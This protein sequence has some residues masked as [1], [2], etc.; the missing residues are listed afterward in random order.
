MLYYHNNQG[1]KPSSV[2]QCSCIYR[3]DVRSF[4]FKGNFSYVFALTATDLYDIVS[5]IS[6]FASVSAKYPPMMETTTNAETSSRKVL[7]SG[8]FPWYIIVIASLAFILF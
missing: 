7:T 1:K 5:P 3:F 4:P 8:I 2:N 6:N